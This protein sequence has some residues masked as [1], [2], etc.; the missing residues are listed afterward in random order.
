MKTIIDLMQEHLTY[1]LSLNYSPLYIKK[2]R[3][4][5]R[6]FADWMQKTYQIVTVDRI[7]RKHLHAWQTSLLEH[8]TYKGRPFAPSAINQLIIQAQAFLLYLA[9]EGYVSK[10]L[11][12]T[13]ECVKEPQLLPTSVLTHA[14]VKKMLSRIGTN[15]TEGYRD[16]AMMELLYTSGV[17]V[18]ELLMLD[19]GDVDIDNSTATVMGKGRKQRVVPVG[20]TAL[21]FLESYLVAVRPFLLKE[22]NERAFF[23]DRKGR[24]LDYQKFLRRVHVY[25]E[26]AGL[27]EDVTPHTFRRSCTTELIRGGA[28]MYHV[29]ELLGHEDLDTLKHYAKLTILDLKKTH[30]KCHPRERDAQSAM[31]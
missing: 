10:S 22:R 13:L 6:G 7:R 29:K 30:E 14:Q 1:M 20:R 15:D 31:S 21:K 9:R 19:V 18:R 2:R 12:D 24:R 27:A 11:A 5:L 8:H 3:W 26:R 17:R 28:N 25:A 23:L 4:S 16:R